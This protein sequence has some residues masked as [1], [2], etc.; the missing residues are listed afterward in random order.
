MLTTQYVPGAPNWIDLGSPDVEASVSFYRGVLGWDFQSAGPE[1]G[2]YGFFQTGGK[3]VAAVGPLTEEGA[4]SSWIVY[5]QTPD[6]DATAKAVEQAGG[7]VR[8]APFDVFDNG[9]MG[10]FSDPAGAR[11]AVWQPGATKGLDA[12]TEP[13]SLSWTELYVPSP[14]AV[15][16]F[17]TAVFGWR[18]EDTPFGDATYILVSPAEGEGDDASIAGIIPLQDGTPHWLPYFEVAD[19]DATVARAGE[20]GGT[21]VVP[22]ADAEGVG[23]FASLTDPHGARFA[24][25]TS[26]AG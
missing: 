26:A 25:I 21:V 6:A 11:F 20:L 3:T 7:T 16:P 13:G 5:F 12:V 23:R 9:R 4:G 8:A 2:G 15:R 22:A 1:A 24:V 17:Y 19:C 14:D 10:Q 18:I